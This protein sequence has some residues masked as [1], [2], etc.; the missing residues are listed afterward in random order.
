[1]TARRRKP[2]RGEADDLEAILAERDFLEYTFPW[3][4]PSEELIAAATSAETGTG[5]VA[6][7]RRGCIVFFA[8]RLLACY[9]SSES[10]EI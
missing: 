6:D 3:L 2:P 4:Q 7:E 10:V 5:A 8:G 9:R 1:M